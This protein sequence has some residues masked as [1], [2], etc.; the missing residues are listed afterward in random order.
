MTPAAVTA[1]KKRHQAH[2]E[3]HRGA[4]ITIGATSY[5]AAVIVKPVQHLPKEDGSGWERIQDLLITVLKTRLATS[6]PKKT[7]IVFSATD[8]LVDEVGG[9]NTNEVAWIIKARR[10]MS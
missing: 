3:L 5:A 7:I 1:A 6:P 9:Q 2:A 4:T 10:R 8:Y